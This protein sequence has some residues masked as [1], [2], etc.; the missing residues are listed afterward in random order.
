MLLRPQHKCLDPTL[1]LVIEVD[2]E[3]QLERCLH[4]NLL[5]FCYLISKRIDENV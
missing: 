5:T 2:I 1:C 3:S 4:S